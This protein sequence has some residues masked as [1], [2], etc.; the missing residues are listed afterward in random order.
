[1]VHGAEAREAE[2]AKQHSELDDASMHSHATPP[3]LTTFQ[4]AALCGVFCFAS[5][6][7]GFQT[8]NEMRR[9]D[10]VLII[11]PLRANLGRIDSNASYQIQFKLLNSGCLTIDILSIESSCACTASRLRQ[12]RLAPGDSTILEAVLSTGSHEGPLWSELAVV[13]HAS[14]ASEVFRARIDISGMVAKSPKG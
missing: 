13:F 3:A 5:A 1:M 2:P 9:R 8:W 14:G 10:V 12:P 6:Y 7:L 11:D 4:R